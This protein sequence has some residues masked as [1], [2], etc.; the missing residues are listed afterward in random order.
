MR[1]QQRLDP[2][3]AQFE[4]TNPSGAVF[5]GPSS[6]AIDP[7]GN[8]FVSNRAGSVTELDAAS[9][10]TIAKNFNNTRNVKEN[11][12]SFKFAIAQANLYKPDATL[13]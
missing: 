11:I 4:S 9:S 2:N 1:E 7:S 5:S 6:I 8:I 12:D 13:I 3:G 10:Y